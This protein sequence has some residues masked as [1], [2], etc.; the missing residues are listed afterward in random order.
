MQRRGTHATIFEGVSPLNFT[1]KG[2]RAPV[3]LPV[4]PPL[5][6][7]QIQMSIYYYHTYHVLIMR[8]TENNQS[9]MANLSTLD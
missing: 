2:A 5:T 1:I 8:A 7:R 4:L 6:H 3:Y 9:M